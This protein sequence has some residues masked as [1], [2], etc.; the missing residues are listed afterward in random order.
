MCNLGK[1]KRYG[2]AG[3]TYEVLEEALFVSNKSSHPI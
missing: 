1:L 2:G 3:R